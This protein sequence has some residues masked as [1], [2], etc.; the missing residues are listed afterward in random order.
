MILTMP[1][2][3]IML[4]TQ[5]MAPRRIISDLIGPGGMLLHIILQHDGQNGS[6][7]VRI[8]RNERQDSGNRGSA[9]RYDLSRPMSFALNFGY[10]DIGHGSHGC[11]RTFNS[12]LPSGA[13]ACG[14]GKTLEQLLGNLSPSF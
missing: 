2:R 5:M 3:S 6:R 12:N 4:R 8:P 13:S 14:F 9:A 11:D 1:H 10:A 7:E